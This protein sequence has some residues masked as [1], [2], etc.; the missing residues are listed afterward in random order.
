[1]S[2]VRPIILV[3]LSGAGKSTVAR[4]VAPL[5]ETAWID[6][7]DRVIARAGK[8]IAEL[9]A[10]QGEGHFRELE[11]QEMLGAVAEPPQVIA[12]GA[13]WVAEP[14]N[15]GAVTPAAFV[16]YLSIGIA[17]AA[18]RLTGVADRPLL[19]GSALGE[20]LAAQ[21]AA[22]EGWYRQADI[23]ISVDGASPEMAAAA[24]VAA[25]RQYG[26]W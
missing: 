21:L 8:S 11:Q 1:M 19:A 24:V 3:G 16:V 7:D 9:F 20:R 25:A 10:E 5:L 22:R 4:L 18:R 13:G 6:I 2:R 17:E 23:E 14:G 26:G 15:L 12:A